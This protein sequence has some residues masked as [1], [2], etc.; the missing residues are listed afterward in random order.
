MKW[1]TKISDT[2]LTPKLDDLRTV[3]KFA[4]FFTEL[5]TG[6]TVWLEKYV[7]VQKYQERW[8]MPS[9]CYSWHTVRRHPFNQY[10]ALNTILKLGVL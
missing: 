3:T 6:S 9:V 10:D 2:K 1:T 5:D 4:W 8:A 7:V